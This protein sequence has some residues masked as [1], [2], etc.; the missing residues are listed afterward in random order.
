VQR[1]LEH[2]N[3]SNIDGL[4]ANVQETMAAQ[5]EKEGLL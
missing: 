4:V 2:N 1:I 3:F 5:K